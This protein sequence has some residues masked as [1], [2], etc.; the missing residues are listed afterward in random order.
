M[1]CAPVGFAEP[2]A[3]TATGGCSQVYVAAGCTG[4][5][6]EA[7]VACARSRAGVTA[8]Q[9]R[10]QQP[11]K[12]TPST[13]VREAGTQPM[14]QR[15]SG[16]ADQ[17]GRDWPDDLWP[18]DDDQAGPGGPAG[19]S[20][21]KGSPRGEAGPPPMPPGWPGTAP[22]TRRVRPGVLAVII[23]AAAAAGPGITAVAVDDPSSPG[24]A[25]SGGNGAPGGQGAPGS[26]F[27]PGGAQP[28][29]GGAQPGGGG[30][31][32]GGGGAVPGGGPGAGP[33]Q[34]GSLFLIGTVTAVSRT[35]ITIGGP[36]H[37]I[38]AVVTGATRVTG[39]VSAVTGIKV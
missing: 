19:D 24:A 37:T 30:T 13:R 23:V 32:P 10:P 4:V 34:A 25:A 27:A 14:S 21:G 9:P 26:Q 15:P 8:V 17:P 16:Q 2:V 38:T 11:G 3:V 1:V 29:G 39:K 36:G 7:S 33:G 31:Q 5:T 18:D 35:S 22:R 12:R 6:P 20:T 28:G